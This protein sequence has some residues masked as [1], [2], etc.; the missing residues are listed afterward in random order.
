MEQFFL[1]YDSLWM[2]ETVLISLSYTTNHYIFI[3]VLEF[4]DYK[5]S[6][7]DIHGGNGQV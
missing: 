5:H 2:H 1:N 3:E 7:I 6:G 4:W